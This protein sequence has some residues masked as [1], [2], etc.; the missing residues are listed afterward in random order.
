[1]KSAAATVDEYL[2]SLPEDQ[3]AQLTAA[4]ELVRARLPAG[5]D[6]S[7]QFGMIGYTV[8]LARFPKTYNGA[9]LMVAALAAQKNHLSLYL[10]GVYGDPSLAEEFTSAWGRTGKKLDMGKSCVRFKRVED[11]ALDAVGEALSR[12][13]PEDIIAQHEKVHGAKKRR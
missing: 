1:M 6:E 2:A 5:F 10:M 13:T 11:L 9:P 8:P 7:M 12:V 4:R 3:R